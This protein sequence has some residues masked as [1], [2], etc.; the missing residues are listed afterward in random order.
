MTARL[1]A[2]LSLSATLSTKHR[3]VLEEAEELIAALDGV[4]HAVRAA[5]AADR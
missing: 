2:L 1:E 4:T 3:A 5:A